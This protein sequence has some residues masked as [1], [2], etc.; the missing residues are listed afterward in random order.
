[1]IEQDSEEFQQSDDQQNGHGDYSG[2]DI[3][4]RKTCFDLSPSFGVINEGTLVSRFYRTLNRVFVDKTRTLHISRNRGAN[5][6]SNKLAGVPAGNMNVFKDSALQTKIV[7]DVSIL[8]D[9]SGSMDMETMKEASRTAFS[10][11]KAL[12]RMKIDSQV[13]YYGCWDYDKAGNGLRGNYIYVAKDFKQTLKKERFSVVS[14][15]G[16]PTHEALHYSIM[17][18][19]LKRSNNKIVFVITDGKPDDENEVIKMADIGRKMGIKFVPIGLGV[20]RVKGFSGDEYITA[21]NSDAVNDALQQAIKLRL[22][23]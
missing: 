15:G 4:V 14:A 10:L 1:M 3:D 22:F 12:G 20:T 7:S 13:S 2:Y 16:T 21:A 9:A 17:S 8:V 19:A 5:L 18:L 23:A 6:L 11:S